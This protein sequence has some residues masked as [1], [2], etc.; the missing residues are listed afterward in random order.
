M[1]V[2]DDDDHNDADNDDDQ[3]EEEE[4]AKGGGGGLKGQGQGAMNACTYECGAYFVVNE[5][6][7][8]LKVGTIWVA[9]A[10][11]LV[12]YNSTC[13]CPF[14]SPTHSLLLPPLTLKHTHSTTGPPSP[15]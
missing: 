13:A 12:L 11:T 6:V 10:C 15:P 14:S 4:E 2:I 1:V 7:R 3:K 8:L 5:K 9:F